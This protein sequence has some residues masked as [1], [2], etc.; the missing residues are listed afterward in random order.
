MRRFGL[1][2]LALAVGCSFID[3]FDKFQARTGDAGHGDGGVEDA[4]EL[5]GAAADAGDGGLD[6]MDGGPAA[7]GAQ[8]DADLADGAVA[9][10]A[11]EDAVTPNPCA[12]AA[13]CADGDP[14]TRDGVCDPSGGCVYPA[15]DED[16]DQDDD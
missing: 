11:A 15:I 5:D 6:R 13:S 9:P 4:G 2:V 3:D 16:G 12:N 8:P 1:S 7:D 14:C 10:D